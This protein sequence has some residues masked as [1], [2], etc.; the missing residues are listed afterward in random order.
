MGGQRGEGGPGGM[1]RGFEGGDFRN[2]HGIA[3]VITSITD[4][5]IVI[6]DRAGKENTI[7]VNEKTIIKNG[8]ADIK[9]T[10]LKNDQSIV[11]IGNP[12][13]NGVVNADLIRVFDN[14]NSQK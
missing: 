2:G 3:G 13:D 14:G 9:I 5:N 10:D 11:V 7:T 4:N 1:M 6:K 12:G 8:A